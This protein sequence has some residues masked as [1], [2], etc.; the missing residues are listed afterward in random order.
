MIIFWHLK[1]FLFRIALLERFAFWDANPRIVAGWDVA[2]SSFGN[3]FSIGIRGLQEKGRHHFRRSS[4]CYWACSLVYQR[5]D[6]LQPYLQP[7]AV[8]FSILVTWDNGLI[9]SRSHFLS[10][11]FLL[12]IC[13]IKHWR[14]PTNHLVVCNIRKSAWYDL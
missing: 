5:R 13:G 11:W 9:S 12:A 8:I 2:L 3:W 1:T 4:E 6:L 14:Q 10:S 7:Y